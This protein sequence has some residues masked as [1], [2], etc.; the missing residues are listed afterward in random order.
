MQNHSYPYEPKAIYG[1][2]MTIRVLVINWS[3]WCDQVCSKFT[4]IFCSFI[5]MDDNTKI[6]IE[7]PW[8]ILEI[9]I[10]HINILCMVFLPQQH[11]TTFHDVYISVYSYWFNSSI[12]WRWWW[13]WNVN[14]S[15]I[16]YDTSYINYQQLFPSFPLEDIMVDLYK[17]YQFHILDCKTGYNNLIT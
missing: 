10:R 9:I 16:C 11:S 6:L 17:Y 15:N 1:L 12:R 3:S 2:S 8:W 14:L 13:R 4:N 7:C 5:T